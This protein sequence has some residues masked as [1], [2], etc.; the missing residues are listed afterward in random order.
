M[1]TT[2]SKQLRAA[3]VQHVT[4][5]FKLMGDDQTN[6]AAEATDRTG[7]RDRRSRRAST[8]REDLRDPVKNYH[9]M[10]M[11]KLDSFTPHFSWDMYFKEVGAPGIK[12]ADIGQLDF[13]Q[14]L[15]RPSPPFR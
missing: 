14:A 2:H 13:F 4:N 6:A 8:K 11:A 5:M 12:S 1:M 10:D 15:T 9:R 3:Y 7:F